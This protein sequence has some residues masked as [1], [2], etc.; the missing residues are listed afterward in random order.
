[1]YVTYQK[2][3]TSGKHA[4]THSFPS[5]FPLHASVT[6]T[7]STRP[8]Y[9]IKGGLHLHFNKTSTTFLFK[10]TASLKIH[11]IHVYAIN[12]FVLN[13]PVFIVIVKGGNTS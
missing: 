2:T 5:C 8:L 12:C 3:G 9:K 11:E 13:Y 7:S 4:S 10:Y 6:T 1:M